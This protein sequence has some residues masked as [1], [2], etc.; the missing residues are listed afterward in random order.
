MPNPQGKMGTLLLFVASGYTNLEIISCL[1]TQQ[2]NIS[3]SLLKKCCSQWGLKSSHGQAHSIESI[4]PAIERVCIHFPKQGSH[5]MKQTL[6]QEENIMVSRELILKYMNIHHPDEHILAA[7]LHDS[8]VF[9]QHDKWCCFQ[10]FLHIGIEPF[11]GRILWLKVWWTNHNPRLICGWYC[12][13]V[14]KLG[15]MPLVTQSDPGT[16]NNGIA[17]GHTMLYHLQ[18]PA[19]AHTLQHKFKGQHR[20]IKPEI[21]W[22]QLRHRWAPGFEDV[23]EF[24]FT[25]GIYNPK[26]SLK[27]LVFHFIFIPWLQCELNLFAERFNN[28]KPHYNMHKILPHSRP[29]DIFYHP[30]KFGSQDFSVKV[31]GPSLDLVCHTYAPSD[32]PVFLLVPREFSEQ[33]YAFMSEL[34]HTKLTITRNNVWDMYADLLMCFQSIADKDHIWS[35]IIGQPA[36]PDDGEKPIG[37]E[38]MNVVDLPPYIEGADETGYGAPVTLSSAER[39]SEPDV[40]SYVN[41]LRVI[42]CRRHS[43]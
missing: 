26:D 1:Q 5:D 7:G 40:S 18:D 39:Y 25:S 24:G 20:N 22:S 30:E 21:F 28:A 12:D 37:S 33:A 2:L 17:N 9:D 42:E 6:L 8:W 19:L 23:L 16:E 3:L 27:R 34:G 11:L 41:P 4:G 10:L 38:E 29:N 43:S 35:V 15:A 13:T 32:H 36:I 31:D 14:N